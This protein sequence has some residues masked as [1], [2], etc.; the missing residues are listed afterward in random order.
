MSDKKKEVQPIA[1]ETW[2]NGEKW[3]A[4][5]MDVGS[6]AE[7]DEMPNIVKVGQDEYGKAHFIGE[8]HR[9]AYSTRHKNKY[10]T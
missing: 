4:V 2:E 7:F 5:G 3:I 10:D 8:I 6:K 9:A 1:Q